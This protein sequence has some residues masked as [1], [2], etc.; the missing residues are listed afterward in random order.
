MMRQIISIDKD[1]CNG[2]GKCVKACH[3]GAITIVNNKAEL[4]S[5]IYCDGFGDCLKGCPQDAISFEY[6]EALSYDEDAVKS[7]RENAV[8]CE[9]NWPIQMKLVNAQM[10]FFNNCELVIASSCSAFSYKDFYDEYRK[11]KVV[12]IGCPKLDDIDYSEKIFS[13]IQNN[14]VKTIRVVLM[15][16]PCCRGLL[17]SVENAVSRCKSNYDIQIDVITCDGKKKDKNIL[18]NMLLKK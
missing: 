3:E 13:I 4:I 12:V 11:N 14:N 1:K 16:V 2:C 5:D 17:K 9:A 7:K 8:K 6:R 18:N 15:E 10:P